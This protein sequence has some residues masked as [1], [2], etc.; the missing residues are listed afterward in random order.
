[1]QFFNQLI[2]FLQQDIAAIFKFIQLVWTWSIAQITQVMHS[3][4]QNWPLWKQA[5][6]VL[7]L[8]A[9]VF[10]LFK[11]AK[12]LWEAGE[13]VL[14]A[15]ATLLGVFVRTLPQVVV[16]GLIAMGGVWLINNLDLSS[17]RVPTAFSSARTERRTRPSQ[18]LPPAA[19]RLSAS[20]RRP[21][22]V[23][24]G[25]RERVLLDELAAR[26]DDVAHQAREDL[27]GLAEVADLHLQQRAHV[28]VER[29]LPQLLGVHLAQPLVA[30]HGD[31]LAAGVVDGI[32]Q[33]ARAVHGR[34]GVLAL[35][36]GRERRRPP[37]DARG[38]R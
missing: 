33:R 24:V 28:A 3:P 19:P 9:V 23:Q 15:F 37:A 5:L 1:M 35:E 4:W 26:L 7:V 25:D 22:H 13:R 38:A 18:R 32:E 31:A 30:L 6:M 16:A 10:A 14:A 2:S 12:E 36:L 34:L 27:V 17:V 8:A 11:V 20:L 29:G 21:S